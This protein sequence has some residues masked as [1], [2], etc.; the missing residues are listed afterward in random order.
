[1][2]LQTVSL[3][4]FALML[5]EMV[6]YTQKRVNGIQELEKKYVIANITNIHTLSYLDNTY[7]TFV[8]YLILESMLG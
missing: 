6:Q 2:K 4:A 8:D 7:S 1:M 5:S 3:S